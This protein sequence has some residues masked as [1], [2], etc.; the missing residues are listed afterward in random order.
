M[1]R[2]AVILTPME[3]EKGSFAAEKA[4]DRVGRIRDFLFSWSPPALWSLTI[5]YFSSL[6]GDAIQLPPFRFVDKLIHFA[7]F[8]TLVVLV[9]R[10]CRDLK[11]GNMC[12][13]FGILYSVLFGLA[14]EI[15]QFYVPGRFADPM[16]FLANVVGI[17][18]IGLLYMKY[19]AN[20]REV[21]GD[22]E[23]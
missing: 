22:A 4:G 15:Y 5:F 18:V 23:V 7:V 17:L 8:G 14:N 11:R 1:D 13:F 19:S 21:K 9:L 10:G 12:T 16:D 2:G 20:R 6:P 3:M